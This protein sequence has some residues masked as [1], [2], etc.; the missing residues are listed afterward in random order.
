MAIDAPANPDPTRQPEQ[1]APTLGP[2][3]LPAAF[4]SLSNRGFRYMWFGQLGAATAMHADL[5]ARGVLVW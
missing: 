5:V 1:A 3:K 4:R 2:I